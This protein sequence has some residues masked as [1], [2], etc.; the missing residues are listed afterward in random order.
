MAIKC[1][2]L[3]GTGKG[4]C[5]LWLWTVGQALWHYILYSRADMP[6]LIRN[7]QFWALFQPCYLS[8]Y[9]VY[10]KLFKLFECIR[11]DD[12]TTIRLWS[13]FETLNLEIV[14]W[15]KYQRHYFFHFCLFSMYFRWDS[16][17][18]ICFMFMANKKRCI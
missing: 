11:N 5:R 16:N 1:S 15:R 8:Y 4:V 12:T 2:Y 18:A 17:M 9:V 7:H 10:S 6:F 13:A 3:V 14:V